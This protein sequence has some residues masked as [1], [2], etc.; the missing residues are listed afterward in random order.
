M[1][2]AT[3]NPTL[4][5]NPYATT[6]GASDSIYTDFSPNSLFDSPYDEFATDF[7]SDSTGSPVSPISPVLS[8]SSFGLADDWMSWDKIDQI[9]PTNT[10]FFKAEPV[11]GPILSSIPPRHLSLSPAINPMELT[12]PSNMNMLS[13]SKPLA[14][15]QQPAN[16][17]PPPV[18]YS[19]PQATTQVPVQVVPSTAARRNSKSLKRKSSSS[20]SD[21]E[22]SSPPPPARRNSATKKDDVLGPKKTAHNMIEK[23]YRTNLN[24]K[25]AQ[26]RDSVPALRIVAQRLDQVEDEGGEFHDAEDLAPIPKLNKAT[27]L[28]KATEY[29]AQLEKRNR[30][31]ETEN[32]M[33]RGRMEGLEMLMMNRSAG[34]LQV[35]N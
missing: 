3:I 20:P 29:I 6:Y 30:G 15:F 10:T 14:M 22:S 23:R 17:I 5:Y 1:T 11:D 18:L 26:L 25:I 27:I 4:S 35:W 31:L 8:S 28:S 21:D 32:N 9:S 24:D 2:G 16:M 33:L 19:S 7:N 13:E 12:M 34:N